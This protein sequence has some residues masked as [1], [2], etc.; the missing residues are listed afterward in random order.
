[1]EIAVGLASR[2]AG[3]AAVGRSASAAHREDEDPGD[4]RREAAEAFADVVPPAVAVALAVG[5]SARAARR[6]VGPWLG[7]AELAEALWLVG[8]SRR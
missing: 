6:L 2:R 4:A 5:G 7:E 8:R 3:L 1:M